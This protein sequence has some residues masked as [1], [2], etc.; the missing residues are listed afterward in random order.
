MEIKP[1]FRLIVII[2]NSIKMKA[3]NNSTN[4]FIPEEE[5]GLNSLLN[6][7]D[8]NPFEV[9]ENYFESLPLQIN[10]R[11]HAPSHGFFSQ[12][13]VKPV[14]R[15]AT[16]FI[17]IVIVSGV[18]FIVM[19]NNQPSSYLANNTSI[20]GDS[21]KKFFKSDDTMAKQ[22]RGTNDTLAPIE[23]YDLNKTIQ[24]NDITIDD[25]IDYLDD[26]NA[27]DNINEL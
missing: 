19:Q 8:A 11:I 7:K 22:I 27:L 18:I 14:Y 15:L 3:D 20:A 10:K 21:N 24:E 16:A 17:A 23:K 12:A 13:F 9:P 26:E 25:V 2:Q 1:L 5:F 6:N 4:K